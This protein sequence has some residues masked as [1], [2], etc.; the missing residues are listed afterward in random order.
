MEQAH[1]SL[2]QKMVRLFIAVEIPSEVK[3]E[4]TR[5]QEIIPHSHVLD[6][7]YPKPD[8]MHLT[9]KFIG[10]VNPSQ[11]AE[12]QMALRSIRF[13][14]LEAQLTALALFGNPRTPKV[15]YVDVEC[16]Q[17][18]DLV[19]EL[20]NCLKDFCKPEEREFKSHLT[21]V[22]VRKTLNGDRILQILGQMDVNHL[23]F[24]IDHVNLVQS[25]LGSEGPVHT[26]IE[27]YD[28]NP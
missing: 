13:K 28:L 12:I 5:L 18:T 20:D 26:L 23:M 4:L 6:G 22:R 7:S 25:T 17:L 19:G 14:N 1:T 11:V 21:V 16:P 3:L 2:T 24:T 9:L 8:A 10:D 27:R 15:L